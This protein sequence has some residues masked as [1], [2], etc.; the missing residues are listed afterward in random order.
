M[1]CATGNASGAK[2]AVSSRWRKRRRTGAVSDRPSFGGSRLTEFADRIEGYVRE[3][4]EAGACGWIVDLRGNG[5]GNMWP[6][7]AG[8]GS[9]LGQGDIGQF[10]GPDGLEG[11][12]FYREGASGIVAP[13][14]E[15]ITT[16]R[17]SGE[18]YRLGGSPP[19]AVMF[20]GGT[21]SSGEATAIA[22]LGRPNVRTFGM[23][24][25]GFT[26]ANDGYR[27]PDGANMVLTVGVDAD[28]NGVAYYDRLEPDERVTIVPGNTIPESAPPSDQDPQIRAALAWLAEQQACRN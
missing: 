21:G 15:V 11:T 28:R 19:V 20:D 26:T 16:A 10:H 12:W 25:F 5:G 17:V 18:P 6:M 27:L 24:S 8:I 1:S 9:V 3:L 7:L 2:H 4:D 13:D 23:P 14:G 22:F